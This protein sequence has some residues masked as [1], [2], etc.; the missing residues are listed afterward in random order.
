MTPERI[1]RLHGRPPL[2]FKC[3]TP[4]Y[5]GSPFPKESFAEANSSLQKYIL[6]YNKAW[7]VVRNLKNSDDQTRVFNQT[8]NEIFKPIN[9]WIFEIGSEE[10]ATFDAHDSGTP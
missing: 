7:F 10:L 3:P 9:P 1:N 8:F 5:E 4:F 2:A 6:A